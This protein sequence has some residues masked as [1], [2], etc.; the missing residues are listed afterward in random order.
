MNYLQLTQRL[1][2][3]S[4]ASGTSPGPSTVVSQTGEYARLATW[5]N[6]A[7]QDIQ[8]AHSDWGWMRASASFATVA[9]Q[10]SYTLGTGAGTV[11]V[12]AAN[13][14]AWVR[15]TGRVYTTS[16]GTNSETML[17]GDIGYDEWRDK[18]YIGALRTSASRPDVVAIGPDKS[19]NFGPV[20]AAGYTITHEYYTGP[21]DLTADTDIPGAPTKFH[22]AIVWRALMMYG[23]FEG[24]ADAYDR[25]ELEFKKLMQRMTSDRLPEMTLGGAL[26]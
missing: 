24:A 12:T 13:F 2:L 5:I 4:G 11:G 7:W 14:G 20:T 9:S 19:L 21:V 16:V 25:G 26:A 8:T 17:N 10:A 22:M 18:Y 1:W 23:A 15:G 3:E 6:A